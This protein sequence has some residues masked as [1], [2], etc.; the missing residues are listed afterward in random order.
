MLDFAENAVQQSRIFVHSSRYQRSAEMIVV[1]GSE[2]GDPMTR[3]RFVALEG[4]Q[5]W[6]SGMM[7]STK[8]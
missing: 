8:M 3:L 1:P 4:M 7:T 2:W 6:D 5:A